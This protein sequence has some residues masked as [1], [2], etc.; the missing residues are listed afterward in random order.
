[1]SKEYVIPCQNLRCDRKLKITVEDDEYG[2]LL[3][4]KCTECGTECQTIIVH[5]EVHKKL[6][7]RLTEA[8]QLAF[9]NDPSIQNVI[10]DIKQAGFNS[11]TLINS[12]LKPIFDQEEF[13]GKKEDVVIQ[14]KK[15]S[16]EEFKKM[17]DRLPKNSSVN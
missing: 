9:K 10:E 13:V 3:L 16:D 17:F 4:V 5:P 1:M 11:I 2:L 15:D 14:E 6:T 7:I 12:F 8:V